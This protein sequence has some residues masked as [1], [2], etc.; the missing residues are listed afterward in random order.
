LKRLAQHFF[1]E[2]LEKVFFGFKEEKST[3]TMLYNKLNY[4]SVMV[5]QQI[6]SF[7]EEKKKKELLRLGGQEVLE[8]PRLGAREESYVLEPPRLKGHEEGQVLELPRLDG[9]KEGVGLEL[10]R[11]GGQGEDKRLKLLR[12]GDQVENERLEL[13]SLGHIDEEGL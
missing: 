4:A 9:K 5:R 3:C 10:T 12:L 11:L 7:N 8:L 13:L 1:T 2:I 6:C